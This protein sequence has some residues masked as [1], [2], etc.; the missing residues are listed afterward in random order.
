MLAFA[1]R[2][3]FL[4]QAHFVRCA[5]FDFDEDGAIALLGDDVNFAVGGSNIL[6]DDLIAFL[7]EIFGICSAKIV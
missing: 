2:D 3:G 6:S 5:R 4:R 1:R 7:C